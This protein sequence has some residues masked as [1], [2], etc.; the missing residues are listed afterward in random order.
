MEAVST[1][2]E[3]SSTDEDTEDSENEALMSNINNIFEDDSFSDFDL[4]SQESQ[5]DDDDD[6]KDEDENENEDVEE[7]EEEEKEINFNDPFDNDKSTE[8]D[9]D[10]KEYDK[11]DLEDKDEKKIETKMKKKM[12]I[13]K[14]NKTENDNDKEFYKMQNGPDTNTVNLGEGIGKNDWDEITRKLKELPPSIIELQQQKSSSNN[15]KKKNNKNKDED[16]IKNKSTK[17]RSF[18]IKIRDVLKED[19]ANELYE[20]YKL[21]KVKFY[22]KCTQLGFTDSLVDI[23]LDQFSNYEK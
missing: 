2:Q 7:E 15:N 22:R 1:N 13:R 14:E 8:N 6:D 12:E 21:S 3:E 19:K 4:E 18:S 10:C 20:L 9:T 17:H 11:L 16:K 23:L 5:Q